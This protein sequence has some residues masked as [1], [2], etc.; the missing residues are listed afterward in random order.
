MEGAPL[1]S[2]EKAA[3]YRYYRAAAV[4]MLLISVGFIVYG[5]VVENWLIVGGFLVFALAAFSVY[6]QLIKKPKK[7]AGSIAVTGS[8]D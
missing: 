7:R 4:L 2:N 8:E 6:P 1:M 5:L 3:K